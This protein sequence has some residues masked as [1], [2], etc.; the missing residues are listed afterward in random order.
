[1]VSRAARRQRVI[2]LRRYTCR[3]FSRAAAQSI[4]SAEV[5]SGTCLSWVKRG[6]THVEQMMSALTP[7][8]DQ[9]ADIL[10]RQLCAKTGRHPLAAIPVQRARQRC[11]TRQRTRTSEPG[12]PPACLWATIPSARSWLLGSARERRTTSEIW[13]CFMQ[14]RSAARRPWVQVCLNPLRLLGEAFAGY[15]R[16][17]PPSGRFAR[18]ICSQCCRSEL[19]INVRIQRTPQ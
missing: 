18:G 16:A 7:I 13:L 2:Q 11:C 3:S 14:P 10:D 19:T 8:A 6:R 4:C 5:R 17:N 12:L 9:Q 1:V 15:S